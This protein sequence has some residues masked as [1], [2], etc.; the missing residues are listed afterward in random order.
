[1]SNVETKRPKLT[2]AEEEAL[3]FGFGAN[4]AD[5]LEKHFSEERLAIAQRH[6]QRQISQ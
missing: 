3:R 1:M 6:R 4:W 2:E 5:Y